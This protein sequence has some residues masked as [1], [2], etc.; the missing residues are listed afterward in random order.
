M[1][2]KR[3][4]RALCV[5]GGAAILAVAAV[6]M[7]AAAPAE[8]EKYRE[9]FDDGD[10]G[11][12]IC[13]TIHSVEQNNTN[14]RGTQAK[15]SGSMLIE[16]FADDGTLLWNDKTRWHSNVIEKDGELQ[17]YKDQVRATYFDGSETCTA[18]M[19]VTFAN[20]EVRNL[21]PEWVWNCK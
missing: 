8:A 5:A 9:C 15:E 4:T 21:G 20:G 7:A 11:N 12:T 2:N 17:V 10:T 14:A 19:N 16:Y 1:F 3:F 6:S 13:Y 18:V